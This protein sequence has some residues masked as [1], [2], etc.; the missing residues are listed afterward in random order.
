MTQCPMHGTFEPPRLQ[1][2]RPSALS[3]GWA[4]SVHLA[5]TPTSQDIQSETYT[6]MHNC[7]KT[8]L[9][10]EADVLTTIPIVLSSMTF[11]LPT[12]SAHVGSY[13]EDLHFRPAGQCH[14]NLFQ[15]SVGNPRANKECL[16]LLEERC[17]P[18]VTFDCAAGKERQ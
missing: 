6:E 2:L 4:S 15:D 14:T 1:P 11:V 18:S 3:T 12:L 7:Q 17:F 5:R 16:G 13:R 10:S 9:D 8:S